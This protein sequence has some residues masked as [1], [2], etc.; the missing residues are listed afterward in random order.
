MLLGIYTGIQNLIVSI[1]QCDE[2]N[3]D[4]YMRV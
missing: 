1:D 3:K 4:I 2:M